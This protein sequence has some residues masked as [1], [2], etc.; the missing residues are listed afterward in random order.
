MVCSPV[1]LLHSKLGVTGP[2]LTNTNV[3]NTNNNNNNNNINNPNNNIF[4]IIR[5]IINGLVEYLQISF[6]TMR[7]ISVKRL[8]TITIIIA[9]DKN[10]NNNNNIRRRKI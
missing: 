3:N 9:K 8:K 2:W 1:N 4:F 5:I 6:N 7:N 10:S